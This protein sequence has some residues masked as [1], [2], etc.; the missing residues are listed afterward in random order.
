MSRRRS[1]PARR[2]ARERAAAWRARRLLGVRRR[3]RSPRA[4]PAGNPGPALAAVRGVDAGEARPRRGTL[5][6]IEP[7]LALGAVVALFGLR[8]VQLVVL[9]AATTRCLRRAVLTYR[10]SSSRC[11]FTAS[12]STWTPS[13]PPGFASACRSP[14]SG[15][16]PPTRPVSVDR[17]GGRPVADPR[18]F[19][20]DPRR[21]VADWCPSRSFV[22]LGRPRLASRRPGDLALQS[23]IEPTTADVE[24][25]DSQKSPA[26][27]RKTGLTRAGSALSFN[28]L[29]RLF[30]PNPRG[31]T[32]NNSNPRRLSALSP[33]PATCI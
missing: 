16:R 21:A 10:S 30:A 5:G 32:G 15:S 28:A 7:G 20:A 1:S 25:V 31:H 19:V 9:S 29:F 18:R 33:G 13:V 23:E 4:H 12:T 6:P 8:S 3:S 24:C 14:A 17:A 26:N 22:S 11:R 2:V 27:R